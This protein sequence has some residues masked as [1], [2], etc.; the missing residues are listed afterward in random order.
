MGAR[1]VSVAAALLNG[2][3]PYGA[4]RTEKGRDLLTFVMSDHRMIWCPGTILSK[5]DA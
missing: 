3:R 2:N 5:I 1:Y 4:L